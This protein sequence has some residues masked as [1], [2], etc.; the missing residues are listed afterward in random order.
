MLKQI[1]PMGFRQSMN[2]RPPPRQ[3]RDTQSWTSSPLRARTCSFLDSTPSRKLLFPL[4]PRFLLAPSGPS[5]NKGGLGDYS[6]RNGVL[7]FASYRRA[8]FSCAPWSRT[9]F[10]EG[11]VSKPLV[12]SRVH[13]CCFRVYC[14]KSGA[15]Q[16]LG[17][18]PPLRVSFAI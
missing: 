9:T 10:Q 18:K 12:G 17:A 6:R 13:S 16:G 4:S 11:S 1:L 7:C 5:V 14:G 2:C 15:R 8:R 3:G